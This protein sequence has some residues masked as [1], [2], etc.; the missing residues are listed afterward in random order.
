MNGSEHDR[1]LDRYA[2]LLL[3]VGVNLQPG[4][5]L[6][7]R[8]S[9]EA[10]ELTRLVVAKAY[11]MGS[12]YV[13]VFWSDEGVTRARFL[14]APD[15][16]FDIVPEH[17][18]ERIVQLAREGAAS[19]SVSADDPD[20]LAGTDPRRMA[21]YL[22]HW[23]PRMKPYYELSMSDRVAWS[24]AAA[25][26]PAWARRVFPDL[27]EDEALSRLWDAIFDAVRLDA[28]D[29]A[30]AWREHTDALRA[31][32]E[33]LNA[34]RY[35]ALRFRGPGTDLRVGLADGHQWDGGASF[36][37]AGVEFVANMPTEEVF[38]APHSR[39]VD[40]VVRATKPLAYAGTLIDGF[41]LTFEGG[42]VTKAVARQG[43]EALDHVLATDAGAR[44]LGEVALVPASSPIARTGLL[45][46]ETLF[47]EN[48]AC[49]IALGQG[50]AMT[51]QGG[52]G[53][54]PDERR[55]A[56]LNESLTHVDFMIGSA[57]LDV[58]GELPTGELEPVMRAGEW[59]D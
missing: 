10:I 58:D 37:P 20:N 39:R 24:G 25:A 47:D 18:A 8:T 56:G 15:G 46:Y 4:Q 19:L 16:S 52:Q 17:Q 50:Y 11:Q 45:F 31:R 48:A 54:S 55:A 26:S 36:T 12:P 28:A 2:D 35:A 53:M 42:A 3:R 30:A 33:R 13:E 7:F 34:R 21:T 40:G 1:R 57:E 9:T 51:L 6:I 22:E 49:H 32:K 27:P 5:K 43:Q 38:T 44:R 14:H 59:V 29:P 41:E 23:R